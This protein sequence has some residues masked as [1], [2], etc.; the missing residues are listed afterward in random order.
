ML[1]LI[2]RPR[3]A[4]ASAAAAAAIAAMLAMLAAAP[5]RA[6]APRKQDAAADLLEKM[7]RDNFGALSRA[8]ILLV[9]AAPH[10]ELPRVGPSDNPN[11]P[12]NDPAH[13]DQWGP[14]R[15]IRAG[16]FAWLVSDPDV[17]P[18]VH[19]SG[20]GIEGARIVG[21]LD[22]SYQ[23][24]ARPLTLV[25][26]AIADGID[27]SNATLGGLELRASR[28]GPIVGDLAQI[29]GD[30]AMRFGHHGP[31][32]IYRAS[33]GGDFDLAG[34]T[35]TGGSAD[36]ISAVQVTIGG[37]A[38]FHQDFTSDGMVDFR[39]ARIGRSLSFN[40]ARFVGTG[41]NGLTAERAVI[42]G[43]LYWTAIAHTARTALDLQNAHATALWDDRASWPS[44]GNLQ[45]DGFSY[46]EFGGDSPSDS[47][48]RLAWLA[49]Q[50]RGYHPQP[51]VELAHVLRESGRSEGST[52]VL[53]AQRVDQRREG[54]L[55]AAEK[56]W[57]LL[58]EATIGYGYR[59]LRALWWMVAF[60][61]V[62]TIVFQRAYGSGMI[63]PADGAAFE[64][65]ARTGHPPR[66]YPHFNA[67]VYS[68]E[69]LLPVVDLHQ[70]NHWRPNA[71]HRV[72]I[73][74]SSGA[75]HVE[76]SAM[77]A[78]LLRFYLWVH[79]LAGWVLT[80][81]MFAGLSGLIRVD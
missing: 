59:P 28:T 30:L 11:D 69:N 27:F 42:D 16:L 29:K 72:C 10:R 55:S 60:V 23:Q 34:S 5:A 45:L 43:P 41:D 38:L 9:R 32:S 12:A 21:R 36:E 80:P 73:D 75:A 46:G 37:D 31:V 79:I 7:A 24:V 44:A 2:Q 26:C 74:A 62:G 13:A 15:C 56:A 48:A 66:H 6:Q 50:P 61:A 76:D 3:R 25:R 67:F 18:H 33:I 81:L 64:E 53:I 78:S 58:L 77:G 17:A 1:I 47:H 68:L 4:A 63:T 19:P 8:E 22:L 52:N 39:L 49:L 20:A 51:Y 40:H 54:H 70:G 71:R 57:N 65:Y 35:F 14:D